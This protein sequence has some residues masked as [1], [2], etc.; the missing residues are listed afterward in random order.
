VIAVFP[1]M[2]RGEILGLDAVNPFIIIQM[3]LMLFVSNP[4][5]TICQMSDN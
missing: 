4:C 5:K 1:I 2:V 3:S